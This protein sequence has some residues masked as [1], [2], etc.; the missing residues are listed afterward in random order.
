MFKH[1]RGEAPGRPQTFPHVFSLF[2]IHTAIGAAGYLWT[3][4][5]IE[6]KAHMAHGRSQWTA[7]IKRARYSE[8]AWKDVF[9]TPCHCAS[10]ANAPGSFPTSRLCTKRNN[11]HI[12]PPWLSTEKRK[13]LPDLPVQ[14]ATQLGAIIP[15]SPSSSQ[16]SESTLSLPPRKEPAEPP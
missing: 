12:G 7:Q 2:S 6:A 1:S 3:N 8:D 10:P 16:S 13:S 15:L 11:I 14:R 5:Q 9:L 4:S